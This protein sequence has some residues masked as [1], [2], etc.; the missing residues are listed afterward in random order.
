M[1]ILWDD[2]RNG[3]S[4][5][6][7]QSALLGAVQREVLKASGSHAEI[8]SAYESPIHTDHLARPFFSGPNVKEKK[9][10][11][12]A[13]LLNGTLLSRDYFMASLDLSL[14]AYDPS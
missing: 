12:A 9:A 3:S 14:Q 11:W 2:I 13:R 7:F 1:P 4:T 6:T 5:H 8:F 10:V